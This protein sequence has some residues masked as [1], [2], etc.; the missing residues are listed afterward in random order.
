MRREEVITVHPL[1]GGNFHVKKGDVLEVTLKSS[2]ET[3][4]VAQIPVT[5]DGYYSAMACN[6]NTS[7]LSAE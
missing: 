3:R 5:E 7:K 6:P 1:L 2:D 4:L